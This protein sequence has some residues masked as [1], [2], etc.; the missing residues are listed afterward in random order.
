MTQVEEVILIISLYWEVVA[1]MALI[2]VPPFVVH[3]GKDLWNYWMKG[4]LSACMYSVSDS[5]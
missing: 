5:G 2:Y 1:L 4:G 3:K